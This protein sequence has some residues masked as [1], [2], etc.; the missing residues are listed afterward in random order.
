MRRPLIAVVLACLFSP[1]A[2]ARLDPPPAPK[3]R[4]ARLA[5]PQ[6]RPTIHLPT[7]WPWQQPWTNLHIA[8]TGP[9]RTV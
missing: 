8:V 1:A 2:Q 3:R 9:P 4:P 6:G 7:Y 5:R